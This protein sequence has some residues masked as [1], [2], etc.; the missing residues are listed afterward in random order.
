MKSGVLRGFL[1]TNMQLSTFFNGAIGFDRDA[2]NPLDTGYAF[3]NAVLG[4]VD[5]YTEST[6][7]SGGAR[8]G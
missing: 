6:P 2:N 7:A 4:T 5:S 8:P 1:G 3:S